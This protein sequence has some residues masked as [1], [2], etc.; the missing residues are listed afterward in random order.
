MDPI[1]T[2]KEVHYPGRSYLGPGTDVWNRVNNKSRPVSKADRAALD[3]DIN[4]ILHPN[5]VPNAAIDDI[6]A[7][8]ESGWELDG[9][10]LKLGLGARIVGNILTL[11]QLFNYN[12]SNSKTSVQKGKLLQRYVQDHY[13]DFEPKT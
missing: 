3:H 9:I 13:K 6:I 7:M 11:G 2:E 10:A 12:K 8:N 4:Y 1:D 5:S